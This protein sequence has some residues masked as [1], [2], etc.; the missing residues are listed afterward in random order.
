[1]LNFYRQA[2]ALRKSLQIV[3]DGSYKEYYRLSDKLYVYERVLEDERLLVICSFSK[4]TLSVKLPKSYRHKPRTLLLS[5]YD[6]G[7][8]NEDVL[9]FRPY[10]AR[11]YRFEEVKDNTSVR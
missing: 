11:V 4:K 5:N 6:A 9:R 1:M 10:E 3:R 7:K 2:V 8:D